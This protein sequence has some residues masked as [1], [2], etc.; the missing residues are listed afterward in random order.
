[1]RNQLGELISKT[2]R[3]PIVV[4]GILGEHRARVLL[5]VIATFAREII[6]VRP[7]QPRA[8]SWESLEASVPDSFAGGVRRGVVDELFS[9]EGQDAL[10]PTDETIVVT[11]SIYLIGEVLEMLL[12]GNRVGDSLLQ[13]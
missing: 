5:P 9:A 7:K 4:T 3:R 10:G 6:L 13:D 1:L 12:H 8:C 11:G 2:G